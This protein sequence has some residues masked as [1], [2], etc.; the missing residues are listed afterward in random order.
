MPIYAP[1][2]SYTSQSTY[3]AAYDWSGVTNPVAN[4]TERDDQ[5]R[6]TRL[7]GNIYAEY[8]FMEGLK[9]RGTL[10]G[11]LLQARR[12]Y[13]RASTMPLNQLLPPTANEGSVSNRQNINWVT[14]HTLTYNRTFNQVHNLEALLGTEFQKNDF[15]RDT[16]AANK[17][18]NDIVRTVNYGTV[19]LGQSFREQWSLASYFARVNYNLK[20]K[21]LLAVSVRRDG[22]S[23]FGTNNQWGTFPSASVGWR[24][25]E[26]PFMK[27]IPVLSELKLRASYGLAGNNAFDNY[28]PIGLLGVDNYVFGNNLS[29]G[30]AGRSLGNED[31]TWEKSR[32][33]DIGT[34]VGLFGDRIYLTA[35]YYRR[36]TTG[37]LF[38]VPIPTLTGFGSYIRNI[39][40]VSNHGWEFSLNTR[41]L[42]GAFNWTTDL[43]LS[44]N[45]NKVLALGPTGDPIRS[46][47]GIGETNITV[48]GEPLGN[49]Y[50]YVQLG[51]FRDQTDLDSYPH[52]ANTRP[53]DV[54]YQDV[55]EDNKIDAN[56]RTLIGNNQPDFVYGMTNTFSFKGFDLGI[57]IQGVQGGEILNLSRRFYENLEGNQNQLTNVLDRWRSPENPGNGIV[58]RANSQTTGT[59]NAVSTRWVEDASY[60]RIRNATLGYN[61]PTTLASKVRMQ[62]ARVYA[63]IQNLY[64]FSKYLGY[65]P[66]VSGYENAL[67]AGVDYGSYPL[68][69]TYTIGINI[70]F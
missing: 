34:E 49:F 12:N 3:A 47:S 52:F 2:G 39:G 54:K 22:S 38:S 33:L 36:I 59:N 8:Q 1:D 28:A 63:G 6:T 32:Q 35:D 19:V 61:I 55:N 51:V 64:T 14:N 31:L 41:N 5:I 13:F 9:Y 42:T 24:I 16:T 53:G 26:E 48:I 40:E 66:E 58:P 65:N 7:L 15:Q 45:R 68:A 46:A 70:G 25:A 20:D 21:Y 43:N 37:L 10:G 62:S 18:P 17:F 69:R 29:N 23:R 27:G 56:D 50:G 30:L 57:V 67:T 60:L 4:I 44:L 11:D